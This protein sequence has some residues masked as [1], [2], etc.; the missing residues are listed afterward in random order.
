[1][2]WP[3]AADADESPI[4]G[5]TIVPSDGPTEAAR[6]ITANTGVTGQAHAGLSSVTAYAAVQI[7]SEISSGRRLARSAEAF[8]T[9]CWMCS[10]SASG[11][12]TR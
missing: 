4:Y 5:R 2:L 3:I 10:R 1:V 11:T 6:T 7:G 12:L 8:A 9:S